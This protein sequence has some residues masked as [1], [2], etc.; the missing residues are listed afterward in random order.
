MVSLLFWFLCCS[1]NKPVS[2]FHVCNVSVGD[3]WAGMELLKEAYGEAALILCA[4]ALAP[5]Y[6]LSGRWM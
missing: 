4:G 3:T 6:I 5:K 2:E 1:S